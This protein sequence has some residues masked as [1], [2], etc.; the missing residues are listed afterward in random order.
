ML[1]T[2]LSAF[3]YI[4]ETSITDHDGVFIALQYDFFLKKASN[5]KKIYYYALDM[6]RNKISLMIFIIKK[7]KKGLRRK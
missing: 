6:A 3:C 5:I 4:A 2:S 7:T 1:K